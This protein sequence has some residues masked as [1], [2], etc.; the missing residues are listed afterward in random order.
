[1]LIIGIMILSA[2]YTAYL[3]DKELFIKIAFVSFALYG[4]DCEVS[5][6]TNQGMLQNLSSGSRFVFPFTL[7]SEP[8]KRLL[9]ADFEKDE[10]YVSIEPQMYDD[11]ISGKG[12]RVLMYRKDKKV[13]V[14]WEPSATFDKKTFNIGGGSGRMSETEMNPACFD[15][16]NYGVDI[17]IAFIDKLGRQVEIVIK[18]N[19]EKNHPFPFLAPVGN[20]VK[21]PNKLFLVYM[22]RFHFLKQEG[23][24]IHVKVGDRK[25]IPAT[26]PISIDKQKVYF[27]RY[28]TQMVIGEINSSVTKPVLLENVRPGIQTSDNMQL[29]INAAKMV[30]SCWVESGDEKAMIKFDAGFPNLFSLPQKETIRGKWTYSVSGIDITGGTYILLRINNNVDVKLDVT[31]SWKPENIPFSFRIVTFLK[32]S[33]RTWPKTYSWQATVNL[34]DNTVKSAWLR[35]N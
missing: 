22:Q 1:M 7:K 29:M 8:L 30:E 6:K 11:T 19:S 23:T 25:L 12:L 17:N 33:F 27:I 14:Y 26:F 35:K 3:F 5:G 28:S 15:Y 16:T 4:K 13:D 9:I 18:E 20:D 32:S 10:E 21:S 31:K 2:G 34:T 24:Y